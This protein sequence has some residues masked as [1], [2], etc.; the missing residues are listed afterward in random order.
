MS[1]YDALADAHRQ[2]SELRL[3]AQERE[4]GRKAGEDERFGHALSGAMREMHERH[5]ADM[6]EGHAKRHQELLTHLQ[7]ISDRFADG[8]ERLVASHQGL[9]E[10]MR[11]HTDALNAHTASRDGEIEVH[12]TG[13]VNTPQGEH[14]MNVV[15]IHRRRKG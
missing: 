5:K 15:E 1:E 8:H 11:A 9:I 6:D 13:T 12:K 2:I 10:A 4:Q 14:K 3:E 7:A